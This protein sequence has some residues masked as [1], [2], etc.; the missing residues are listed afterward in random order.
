MLNFP[1]LWR[2]I[3]AFCPWMVRTP[4]ILPFWPQMPSLTLYL[5]QK[6]PENY[7]FE[8]IFKHFLN[9]G[10]LPPLI[11]GLNSKFC[12]ATLCVLNWSLVSQNFVLKSY[13]Y[14]KLPRKNLWEV[15]STPPPVDQEGLKKR[16]VHHKGGPLKIN[17]SPVFCY[18]REV[19]QWDHNLPWD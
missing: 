4:T 6:T 14:Q 8:Q 19:T 13:L 9:F 11:S 3:S 12:Y 7:V 15:G 18:W 17:Y 2:G 10:P 16:S 5:S 1:G